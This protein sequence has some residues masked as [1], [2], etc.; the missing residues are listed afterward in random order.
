MTISFFAIASI[1]FV[2]GIV[3][4]EVVLSCRE[5]RWVGLWPVIVLTVAISG[6]FGYISHI[7]SGNTREIV[8]HEL[9]NGNYAT[10]TLIRNG[11]GEVIRY[12]EIKI[13]NREDVQV[14]A[15][16]I[17]HDGVRNKADVSD[18]EKYFIDK[19]DLEGVSDDVETIKKP[20]FIGELTISGSSGWILILMYM[21]PLLLVY[22]TVRLI[23]RYNRQKDEMRRLK[24]SNWMM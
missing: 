5:N 13:Y 18:V 22:L 9:E 17:Y 8:S 21:I 10:M 2:F 15:V 6:C 20:M 4:L 11:D 12:G 1:L 24:I 14:D 16:Y 3:I 23:K 19:Y 7:N